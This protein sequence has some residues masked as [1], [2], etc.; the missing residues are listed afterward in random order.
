MMAQGL[1]NAYAL[2]V[3]RD[4]VLRSACPRLATCK[5][6]GQKQRIHFKKERWGSLRRSAR[7]KQSN[8]PVYSASLPKQC[9]PDSGGPFGHLAVQSTLNGYEPMIT[10]MTAH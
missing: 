5:L 10:M 8:K 1:A 2:S 9:P 3:K 6:P 7:H 4:E